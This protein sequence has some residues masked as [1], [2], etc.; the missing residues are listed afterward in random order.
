[1]ASCAAI[2][3]TTQ[4]TLVELTNDRPTGD[5]KALGEVIGSQGNW[6]TGDVTSNKNLMLGARND[7]RNKAA[8]LGGN[9]VHVQNLSNTNASGSAGTTNT[10]VTGMVYKCQRP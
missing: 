8:A 9:V 10:T 6:F 1:M 2:Q 7:L 4:G 5:C 3:T